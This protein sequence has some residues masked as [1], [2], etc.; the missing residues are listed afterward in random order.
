[1]VLHDALVRNDSLVE[2]SREQNS[3]ATAPPRGVDLLD[4]VR[5]EE[6]QSGGERDAGLVTVGLVTAGVGFLVLLALTVPND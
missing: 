1:M 5:L 6:W 4:V 3:G 2:R